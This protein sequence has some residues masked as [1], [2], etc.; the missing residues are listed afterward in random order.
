MIQKGSKTQF[1]P[2]PHPDAIYRQAVSLLHS[3]ARPLRL[4]TIGLSLEG[5]PS[6][7][8]ISTALTN[9]VTWDWSPVELHRRAS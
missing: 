6:F 2:I 1:I 4:L 9:P 7:T 8:P 3:T 5:G